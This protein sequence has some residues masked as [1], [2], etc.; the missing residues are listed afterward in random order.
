MGGL[1]FGG[2]DEEGIGVEGVVGRGG[3]EGLGLVLA[4]NLEG[5]SGALVGAFVGG[6]VADEIG[7]GIVAAFEGFDGEV[8]EVGFHEVGGVVEVFALVFDFDAEGGGGVGAGAAEEPG[9]FDHLVDELH[10]VGVGGAHAFEEFFA[11]GGEE[12]GVFVVAEA[13]GFAG[14]PVFG[15]VAGGHGE[16]VGRLAAAEVV[17]VGFGLGLIRASILQFNRH[18]DEIL[19][20]FVWPV[21]GLAEDIVEDEGRG[22]GAGRAFWEGVNECFEWVRDGKYIFVCCE[23][24]R[25]LP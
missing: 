17:V 7:V 18:S 23:Q 25:R 13:E 11:V 5:A 4:A 8:A 1:F 10:F 19:F 21:G 16:A 12:V 15:G 9:V 20:D 14:E 22:Q 3:R 2:G 24:E 6:G